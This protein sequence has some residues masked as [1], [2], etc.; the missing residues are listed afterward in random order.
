MKKTIPSPTQKHRVYKRI[1]L[2]LTLLCYG[3][4]TT[5]TIDFETEND[6]YTASATEGTGYT[7]IFNRTNPDLGGNDTYI[8]AFEDL[9][10]E[11]PTLTIDQI[12]VSGQTAFTFALDLLAHHY[13]DWDGGGAG[14]NVKIY[15]SLD[16]G[17]SWQNLMWV[18]ALYGESGAEANEPAAWLGQIRRAF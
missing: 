11:D 9:T 17:S 7:D 15:Y 13:N 3:Y 16:G 12:D 10:I 8:W 1:S 5:T 2:L 14:D 4:A 6:G 18:L